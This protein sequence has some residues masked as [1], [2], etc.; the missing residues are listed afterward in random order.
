MT[1]AQ[2]FEQLFAAKLVRA[3]QLSLDA[4]EI[5]RD[6]IPVVCTF[7]TM[8][9]ATIY[10]LHIAATANYRGALTCLG[11]SDTSSSAVPPLRG[12]LEA[13]AHLDFIGDD[14]QGGDSRCR[15]LRYERGVMRAWRDIADGALADMD[16][17]D[18][19]D[20][21]DAKAQEIDRLWGAFGCERAPNRT[22]GHVEATLRAIAQRLSMEWILP[23]WRTSSAITH[24]LGPDF[25]FKSKP[26]DSTELVWAQPSRRAVWLFHLI[27]VY[28]NLT[29]TAVFGLTDGEGSIGGSDFRAAV[30]ALVE[31]TGLKRAMGGGWD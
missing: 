8:P 22:R 23:I 13:W 12:M 14:T 15:S 10:R 21:H 26:D 27:L 31:D 30:D 4:P 16:I 20:R 1:E 5:I 11:S 28:N 9:Q 24:L 18:W 3:F 19:R 7:E 2:D 25:A 17:G 29:E 6:R